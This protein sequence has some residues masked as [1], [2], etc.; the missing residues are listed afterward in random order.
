MSATVL[1]WSQ[2]ENDLHDEIDNNPNS[3]IEY[4]YANKFDE[5]IR[6]LIEGKAPRYWDQ[7]IQKDFIKEFDSIEKIIGLNYL[8]WYEYM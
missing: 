2:Y 5:I 4:D 3:G 8:F 7:Q 6:C 1:L